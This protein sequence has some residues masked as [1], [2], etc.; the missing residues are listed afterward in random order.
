M[1]EDA[2]PNPLSFVFFSSATNPLPP[3]PIPLLTDPKVG[4]LPPDPY[5]ERIFNFT[6]WMFVKVYRVST[7][8]PHTP[9]K[10]YRNALCIYSAKRW[11]PLENP[12]DAPPSSEERLEL[13]RR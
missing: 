10:D 7:S 11:Y 4:I 6:R 5:K 13:L 9:R 2:V 1:T 8:L 12:L 3:E